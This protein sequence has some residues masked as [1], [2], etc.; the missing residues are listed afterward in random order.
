M[1]K[2]N[3]TLT[4][5]LITVSLLILIGLVFI[6]SSSSVYALE[7]CGS[8]H[9]FV[10]KQLIGLAL[11]L[12]GLLICAIIP[13]TWIAR[14]SPWLLLSSLGLTLLTLIPQF[15]FAIH[16]SR[17]WLSIAGIS[18]QPSELLKISLILYLAYFIAKK[19]IFIQ[20]FMRGYLP[21]LC[22]LAI[23]SGVLLLQPDFG[24]A[25]TLSTTGF[26]MCFLAGCQVKYL[27]GTFVSLVPVTALLIYFK[28]YRFKRILTFLNPWEDRQGAGFQIIQ[29]LIAIGSGHWTGVG[30]A[31]SRQ[32]FFYLPMQHT[33]FIFSIIAEEIGFIGATSIVLLY[34]LFLYLGLRLA[35]RIRD[36]FCSFTVLGFV[37]L[38]S[39]QAAINILVTTGLLPTKGLGLPFISYGNSALIS[40]LCMI[41][42]II[43]C[44][45][46]G[47]S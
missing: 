30:I 22:V 24:Q 2:K 34:V 7:K 26:I 28:P 25:V 21:L 31:Q 19:D 15:S 1:I 3:T 41:G 4:L 16:G 46:E 43:N 6:Y 20:S 33:D 9:F 12:V 35:W 5:F 27:L 10:R 8:A 38:L 45:Q 47:K 36:T 11:G 37:I 29:S 17:R 42:L 39:L 13:C 23:T 44:V 40:N 32:K 14:L 18:L